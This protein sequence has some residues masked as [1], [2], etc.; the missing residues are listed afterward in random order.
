MHE[1]I[2]PLDLLEAT[3]SGLGWEE[4]DDES[5]ECVSLLDVAPAERYGM[6]RTFAVAVLFFQSQCNIYC[7]SVCPGIK[8]TAFISKVCFLGSA[9][10]LPI[11]IS[12]AL[13][14][15][16]EE[17]LMPESTQVS[18]GMDYGRYSKH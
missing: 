11:I 5:T 12:A 4:L 3:I 17:K 2:H 10:T 16:Q 15:L 6:D 14:L 8:A 9:N 7:G 13:T 18:Y 1:G